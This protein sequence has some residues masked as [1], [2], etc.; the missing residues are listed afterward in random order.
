MGLF[1]PAYTGRRVIYGHPFETV[2][3][4]VQEMAVTRFFD[5]SLSLDELQNFIADY[6]VDLVFYGSRERALR[7]IPVPSAWEPV[8]R[9]ADVT[10]FVPEMP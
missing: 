4:P 8:F 2:D 6:D 5:G 9:S 3:A 7:E 10:L 1:I